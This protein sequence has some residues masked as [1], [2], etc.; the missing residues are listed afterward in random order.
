MSFAN[1]PHLPAERGY[2]RMKRIP[3]PFGKRADGDQEF[4]LTGPVT[5]TLTFPAAGTSSAST[6][7]ATSS[8][9]PST[10]TAVTD[11]DTSSSSS[12]SSAS[13]SQPPSST[14]LSTPATTLA[15]TSTQQPS[16]SASVI[17]S[18]SPSASS[19]PAQS[20]ATSSGSSGLSGGAT[21]GI[22]IVCLVLGVGVLFF[23]R[24]LVLR[25]RRSRKSPQWVNNVTPYSFSEK[26]ETTGF[27]AAQD[28]PT[29]FIAP[30][31]QHNE[32][33]SS[34][35]F[36][37][38]AAPGST[39]GNAP[40]QGA[41][42]VENATVRST[43]VPSLPD[44]LSIVTGENVKIIQEFDDGWALCKNSAGEQGMV[45]LECLDRAYADTVRR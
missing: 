9:V 14:A 3:Q 1:Q 6:V 36:T 18:P 11:T 5:L 31:A 32:R 10:Q 25:R 2:H 23:V 7:V 45:P 15:T 26:A 35:N 21:A 40:A 37:M 33:R 30:F 27:M 42:P 17:S 24:F 38:P 8:R 13:S 12:S 29:P 34:S 43:F 41:G 22:V 44:E 28:P 4:T 39:Y 20:G 16:A 19:T